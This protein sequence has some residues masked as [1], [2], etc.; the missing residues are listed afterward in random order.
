VEE[1][2][3]RLREGA[4]GYPKRYESWARW[5]LRAAAQASL[6][7]HSADAVRWTDAIDPRR[8]DRSLRCVYAHRAAS[9]RIGLGDRSG[10]RVVLASAPRPADPAPVEQALAALDGLLD[11]LDGDFVA[12]LARAAEALG[13]PLDAAARA[14]WLAARAHALEAT[15]AQRE[16]REVLCALQ[17]QQGDMVIKG[18]V[19]HRGPASATAAV[20]LAAQGPYR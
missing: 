9:L 18:I 2:L 1:E 7:G 12:A 15:G 11:A 19:G 16:A 8:L 17:A 10:A 20:L 6:A 4:D 5:S 13:A 3:A 14:T